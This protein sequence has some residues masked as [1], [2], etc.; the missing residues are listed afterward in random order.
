MHMG[1]QCRQRAKQQCIWEGKVDKELSSNAISWLRNRN[2]K[3]RQLKC[4]RVLDVLALK[5]SGFG[6]VLHSL[7]VYDFKM[8]DRSLSKMIKKVPNLYF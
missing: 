3:M 2:M 7:T 4:G 6:Q 5:I 8:A 1:G